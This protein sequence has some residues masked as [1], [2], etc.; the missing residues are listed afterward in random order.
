MFTGLIEST[1][2]FRFRLRQGRSSKLEIAVDFSVDD[3]EIGDSIAVNGVCLTV[4]RID[5]ATGCLRFHSLVE[6]LEC[7]NLGGLSSGAVVNLERA[8]CL[9]GRLGGHLVQGHVDSTAEIL[10]IA[11][12]GEETVFTIALPDI[13]VPLVI[14][15]GS[16]A[17][18]GISLTIAR[19]QSDRFAVHVIPHTLAH[20]NLCEASEGDLVN[21]EADMVGKY[22]LRQSNGA[23]G[24]I[25]MGDLTD[26]GFTG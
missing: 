23:A 3:V 2:E 26:A 8:L 13:L 6:T 16:I 19:L 21:L 10:G 7:T 1:G 14:H 15:R 11:R 25:T 20:T 5:S 17:V 24:G 9:G 18:D 4:E 22:V 12:V